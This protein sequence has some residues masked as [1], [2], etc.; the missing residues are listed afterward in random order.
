METTV[1]NKQVILRNYVKGIPKESDLMIITASD[2]VELKVKPGSAAVMV[3]NL[4]LS[5]D[6]YMGILMREPTPSTLALLDA[7]IPGKVTTLHTH[8]YI[9]KALIRNCC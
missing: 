3:R 8:T 2:P 9:H 1:K 6:P 5:C 7:F 4:Y